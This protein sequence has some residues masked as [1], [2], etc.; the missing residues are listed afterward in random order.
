MDKANSEETK[1]LVTLQCHWI[2]PCLKPASYFS[3][4]WLCELIN[5]F[6][7]L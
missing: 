3:I 5:Y 7:Y 2:K 1:S 4:P 6:Y